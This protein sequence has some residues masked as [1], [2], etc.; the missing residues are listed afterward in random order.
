MLDIPTTQP[1][2]RVRAHNTATQQLIADRVD[3]AYGRVERAVGLLKRSGLEP[4][5]ALWIAPSRGV[6]TCGMRFEIDVV[7]LDGDGVVVDIVSGMKPWRVRMPRSGTEGV[8]ELRAG[9]AKASGTQI[10]HRIQFEVFSDVEHHDAR[11][12]R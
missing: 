10:G 2:L 1:V 3:I 7:A 5:E 9:A 8:L 4:G 12:Y 6:H 11:R